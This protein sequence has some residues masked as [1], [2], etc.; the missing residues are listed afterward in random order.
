MKKFAYRFQNILNI[1]GLQEEEAARNFRIALQELTD[2]IQM[3]DDFRLE[4]R[5]LVDELSHNVEKIVNIN[6]RLLYT[7][8][9]K[10]LDKKITAQFFQVQEKEKIVEKK[11]ELLLEAV[12]EKKI[13]EKLRVKDLEKYMLELRR[14]E[15][16]I[17]DD[18]AIQRSGHGRQEKAAE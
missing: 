13:L 18:L 9:L 5:S 17:I 16:E 4:Y 12:K 10:V 3:L 2:C 6:M 7:N 11:R 8:Y 15:Q 1:R 14:W